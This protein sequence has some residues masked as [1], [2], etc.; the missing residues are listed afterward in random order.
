MMFPAKPKRP[1][2][3]FTEYCLIIRKRFYHADKDNLF[4]CLEC[5]GTGK[6]R[7]P[8]FER[9]VIEGYKMAGRVTCPSCKGTGIYTK[10]YYR[11]IYNRIINERTT[12]LNKY[13][14]KIVPINAA[15]SKL[16]AA[17]R[18][19]LGLPTKKL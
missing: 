3:N 17:E 12:T 16:T 4:P 18:K 2:K 8:N 13:K 7:D 11:L 5:E 1:Y 9:D 10:E 14:E 15:L 19:I 6:I